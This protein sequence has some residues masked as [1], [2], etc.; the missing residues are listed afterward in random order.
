[1]DSP[2]VGEKL[3]DAPKRLRNCVR[4][5]VMEEAVHEDEVEAFP[6]QDVGS[7]RVGDDEAA[8]VAI[9]RALDVPP[10][11]VKAC[12]RA[13]LEVAGVRPRTTCEIEDAADPRQVSFAQDRG[14]LLIGKRGLPELVAQT[15][16][17]HSVAGPRRD[18]HP[19]HRKSKRPT[20][21]CRG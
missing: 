9:S 21:S 19:R 3:V 7:G 17:H 12:I 13:R 10:V 16:L 4:R 6:I 1:M 18:A 20:R 15:R 2:L 11:D 8:F 14:E 5:Q